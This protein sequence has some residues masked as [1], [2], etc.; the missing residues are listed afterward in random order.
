MPEENNVLIQRADKKIFIIKVI[1]TN[2]CEIPPIGSCCRIHISDNEQDVNEEYRLINYSVLPQLMYTF[3]SF[4][5]LIFSLF[6]Q[7]KVY[8]RVKLI[9][10]GKSK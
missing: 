3:F 7:E 6:K 8:S 2:T 4:E 10:K 1:I 9:S 5:S